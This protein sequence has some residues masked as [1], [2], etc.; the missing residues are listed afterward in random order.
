MSEGN[1]TYHAIEQAAEVIREA[2]AMVVLTG[3]GC[4]VE[5]GIPDFRSS[6]GWWRNIDP[7]TE[8]AWNVSLKAIE[9]ADVVLVMGTSLQM[10]PVNQH[11]R[12]SLRDV[13]GHR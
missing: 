4:S 5:A 9:Q 10:Y 1:A 2:A 3:A 7:R 13:S 11:S 12:K 6:T 8:A